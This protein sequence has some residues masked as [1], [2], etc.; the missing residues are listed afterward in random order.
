MNRHDRRADAAKWREEERRL[1]KRGLLP[2]AI[3]VSGADEL[4][5]LRR[6][7][8]GTPNAVEAAPATGGIDLTLAK[9]EDVV[10]VETEAVVHFEGG[11][12]IGGEDDA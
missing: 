7:F 8:L 11:A 5:A 1:R 9:L 2:K 4:A 6:K 10:V 3:N 12:R